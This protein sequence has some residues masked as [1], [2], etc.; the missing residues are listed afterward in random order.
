MEF[1]FSMPGE[2]P[3]EPIFRPDWYKGRPPWNVDLG[4]EGAVLDVRSGTVPFPAVGALTG[5][6]GCVDGCEACKSELPGNPGAP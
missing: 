3:H 4:R 2:E 6:G 1:A 5:G